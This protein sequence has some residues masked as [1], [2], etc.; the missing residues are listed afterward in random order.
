VP[1]PHGNLHEQ[2]VARGLAER[3]VDVLE[4]LQVEHEEREAVRARRR[5]EAWCSTRCRKQRARLASP[6]STS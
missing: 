2:R 4:P 1:E 6:V 5:G 3:V